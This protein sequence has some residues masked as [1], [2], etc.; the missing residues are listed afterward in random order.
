MRKLIIFCVITIF[1]LLVSSCAS[2]EPKLEL[3]NPEAFAFSLDEGWEINSSAN[4]KG[5][6]HIQ[7]ED[8]FSIQLSYHINLIN[9]E[10]DTLEYAD[11]GKIEKTNSEQFLDIPIESQIE[12]NGTFPLG[13]Y[14]IVFSVFDENSKQSVSIETTVLI[15]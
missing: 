14:K 11:F 7:S 5:I 9:P 13:E 15:E 4:V 1:T 3:F 8:E 2:D 12:L 6:K 10:F